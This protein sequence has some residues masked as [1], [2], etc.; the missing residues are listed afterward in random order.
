LIGSARSDEVG[1]ATLQY[2][3]AVASSLVLF[4][5]LANVAVDLY[6]R[7]AVRAAVDEAARTGARLDADVDDCAA[8]AGDVLAGLLGE[9]LRSGVHVRCA[10]DGDVVTARA[11]VHLASWIAPVPGWSFSVVG[12]AVEERER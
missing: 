5:M 4:V 2:V 12:T 8:R 3:V 9:R 1:T 11:E 6:A 10:S 7:G